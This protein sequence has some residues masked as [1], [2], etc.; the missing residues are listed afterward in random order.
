M[1]TLFIG[2]VRIDCLLYI[3]GSNVLFCMVHFATDMVHSQS[4]IGY[5]GINGFCRLPRKL[6]HAFR[7]WKVV[8]DCCKIDRV[9]ST[10]WGL[11]VLAYCRALCME[12]K[13]SGNLRLWTG[14]RL[15]QYANRHWVYT[16]AGGKSDKDLEYFVFLKW[17]CEGE[18]LR[19][20]QQYRRCKGKRKDRRLAWAA[21]LSSFEGGAV[22]VVIERF[23]CE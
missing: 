21:L 14:R 10:L 7:C 13:P 2:L 15:L 19:H 5:S 1:S 8:C 4:F 20:S 16:I 17:L 11:L 3:G 9:P 6:L 22:E 12:T 23:H 18:R